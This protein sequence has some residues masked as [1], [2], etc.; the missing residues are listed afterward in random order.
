ME[1]FEKLLRSS[2][3][4]ALGETG[5]LRIGFGF[6]TFELVP[7]LIVQLRKRHPATE[8]R[9]SDMSTAEQV[10]ALNSRQIDVGFLREPAPK[11]FKTLPVITDRLALISSPATH[12]AA[13]G[14]LADCRDEP[15]VAI[16][17]ARSPGFH[18]HMLAL[19]ARHGFHPRI[20][21]QVPEFTTA[22]AL[23]RA[24]LGVALMPESFWTSRFAGIRLHPIRE[25]A[26]EWQVCAA[27]RKDDTNPVLHKFLDL[28]RKELAGRQSRTK[29]TNISFEVSEYY[30]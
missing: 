4:A 21:Q 15:F 16:S 24:G 28:L 23:V 9:L 26:A 2:R 5:K 8:V 25:K 6:H 11:T 1:D 18:R 30:S 20:V 10:E 19:C 22:L 29:R 27:W 12:L 13:T 17:E 3:R 7:R 14:T